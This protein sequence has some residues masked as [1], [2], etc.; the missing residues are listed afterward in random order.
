MEV[1]PNGDVYWSQRIRMTVNCKMHLARLPYDEQL[2]GLKMGPYS[3]SEAE[4][5]LKWTERN[6]GL[7]LSNLDSQENSEWEIG[8]Q[9]IDS[10]SEV[11]SSGNYSLAIV[12]FKLTRNPAQYEREIIQALIF[13]FIQYL[14]VWIDPA[15]AP[16]R[17]VLGVLMV[18]IVM[19]QR[20]AVKNGLPK[21]AGGVWLLDLLFGCFLLNIV[22]F[23]TYVL[24]NFGMQ[25]NSR[26]QALEK[27]D[28]EQKQK[29]GEEK[30]EDSRTGTCEQ[31]T[32]RTHNLPPGVYRI[33]L[34]R[35]DSGFF[36]NGEGGSRPRGASWSPQF[37]GAFL[38][39]VPAVWTRT[40]ACRC[41][42][43]R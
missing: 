6:N 37:G 34:D 26:L 7:A 40:C 20:E 38:V 23:F 39:A 4:V 29:A 17:I 5:V 30:K 41:A 36:V 3:Q 2:C 10:L 14:G 33:P 11:Y 15:A 35:N 18:L 8:T 32:S 16:G 12:S 13:V 28:K 21:G 9:E 42:R 27:A 31:G 22:C 19:N 43:C 1:Y 24:V 25:A